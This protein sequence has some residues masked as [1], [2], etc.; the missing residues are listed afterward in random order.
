MGEGVVRLR[1]DGVGELLVVQVGL[2]GVR[3]AGGGIGL[4]F[5][6][7]CDGLGPQVQAD[8]RRDGG[9]DERG[10]RGRDDDGGLADQH[11]DGS[12]GIAAGMGFGEEHVPE[13]RVGRIERVAQ[14]GDQGDRPARRDGAHRDRARGSPGEQRGHG[15]QGEHRIEGE[16]D[17]QGA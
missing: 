6:R 5:G 11:H 2:Q 17:D 15:H 1:R 12:A 16:G 3:L 4:G 13:R 14:L 7:G 9:G 8:E 10:D